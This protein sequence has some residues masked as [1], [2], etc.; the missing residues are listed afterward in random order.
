MFFKGSTTS[1]GLKEDEGD[2]VAICSFREVSFDLQAIPVFTFNPRLG[3]I[4]FGIMTCMP[5][6][7]VFSSFVSC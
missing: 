1:V 2:I 4:K 5:I 3:V 7:K 6:D